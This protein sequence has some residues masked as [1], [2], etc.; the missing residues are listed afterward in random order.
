MSLQKKTADFMSS[1]TNILYESTLWLISFVLKNM[2]SLSN[3][4][5]KERDF[6][7]KGKQ[8]LSH[9]LLA[10]C[11]LAICSYALLKQLGKSV[12]EIICQH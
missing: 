2:H 9:C 8:T 5:L 12:Y 6:N 4:D 3:T 11:F 7:G 10:S 1:K